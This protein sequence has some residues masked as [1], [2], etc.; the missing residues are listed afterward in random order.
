MVGGVICEYADMGVRGLA[1]KSRRSRDF[2]ASRH[3]CEDKKKF[4][5]KI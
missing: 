4:L 1:E 3:I 2:S 5:K